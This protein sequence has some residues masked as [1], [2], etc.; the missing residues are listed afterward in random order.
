MKNILHLISSSLFLLS[1]FSLSSA[2][3]T[4][5]E[6]TG[7]L[8]YKSQ[9]DN[10]R[11]HSYAFDNDLTTYYH[12]CSNV[13]TGDWFGWDLGSRHVITKIAF[14]PRT[15][16][17][18]YEERLHLGIFQGANN[19]DFGDAVA[20]YIIPGTTP[21]E[22]TEIEI[23]NTKGFRY[24]RFVF[25]KTHTG[26]SSYLSELK[27]YGYEGAG[28]NSLLPQLTNLPTISIQTVNGQNI[29][30]KE[31][32]IKGIISVVYADGTKFYTDSL[33]IRGR[34]NNS[35]THPKKPYRIRLFNSVNFMDLPARARNWTL[36]NNYGDKTLMRNMLAFDFSKRLEMPYTSPA[37]GVDVV[38]NGD[39]IGCYQL[40]DHIDIRRNRAD[41]KEMSPTDL[42]GGYMV[43][44]DAYYYDEE[45]YFISNAYDIPVTI[46]EPGSALTPA[47]KNY[48]ESHFNKLTSAVSS[49]NYR[50]E[51]TG[52]RRYMDVE[53]F[54]RHFLVGEY[55]GNTDTYWSVRMTKDENDDKFRFGPLWDFDLG[56]ENDHRTY[57]INDKS[58]WICFYTGGRDH[59]GN[60]QS[61]A[62]AAGGT[63]DFIRRI[64]TDPA[65]QERLVEIYS[66]YRDRN[67]VSGEVLT[68]VVDSLAERLAVSQ[69]LNFK[70]WQIMN[71]RVHENP[72]VHGSYEGEVENVRNY[73]AER[74]EWMDNKLNYVP[75]SISNMDNVPEF[76]TKVNIWTNKNIIHL[77][78]AEDYIINI[79]DLSGKVIK[80]DSLK[81]GGYYFN[82]NSG[83][84][85][86]NLIGK[87]GNKS[88]YKCIVP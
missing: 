79:V 9:C 30:S 74:I 66:Y 53:T 19:P 41:I 68:A 42:T 64:L 81:S 3:N 88:L 80:S 50:N 54:L 6:L 70:R 71:T 43:E 18:K 73:V 83:A 45:N 34:G 29:T 5:T 10:T 36:I 76:A 75:T 35:W 57:P 22:I 52:F 28:N 23:Q 67:I 13:T 40:C 62:S 55:T 38:L 37:E 44:I 2:Q 59:N 15:D 56:F 51:T 85:I 39:Y 11:P 77:N 12:S 61:G 46:K 20:L 69:D 32:Y 7:T 47:Q 65:I 1:S 4:S 49:S 31:R 16:E 78:I 24:V 17:K 48:I 33:E 60:W 86:V 25:P 87:D 72:V 63:R 21:R 82:I 58:E 26:L 27:F 14:A 8:I 84:Y